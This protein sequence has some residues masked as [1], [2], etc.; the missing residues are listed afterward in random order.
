MSGKPL[1]PALESIV[2]ENRLLF[3]LLRPAVPDP[4]LLERLQA[5][6][7][8][9]AARHEAGETLAL[10]SLLKPGAAAAPPFSADLS[11]RL[12]S[13]PARYPRR[14]KAPE[15]AAAPSRWRVPAFVQDWRFAVALAYAAAFFLVAVLGIDPLSAAR[16]TAFD[17]ASTGENAIQEARSA[18]G[19]RIAGSTF[20]SGAES[21][22]RQLDY[23]FYRTVEV[24]KA[25]AAA[26]GSIAVDRL[27]GHTDVQQKRADQGRPA[28]APRTSLR[29]PDD[30]G[31]RS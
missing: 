25:R 21:L 7:K 1:D 13:I 18:A 28:P 5:I 31:F 14:A 4:L 3:E 30:P 2:E 27:F 23:R 9:P 10:L 24:T 11:A 8:T 22:S 6:G 29:E 16:R 17:L 12:C 19:K 26:W 20:A 15:P